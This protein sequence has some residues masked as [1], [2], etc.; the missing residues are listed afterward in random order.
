VF[1]GQRQ[2]VCALGGDSSLFGT[3]SA[4]YGRGAGFLGRAPNPRIAGS[5]TADD[6]SDIDISWVV[7]DQDFTEAVDTLGA[8]VSQVSAVLSVRTVTARHQGRYRRAG[9][10][11]FGGAVMWNVAPY[12]L[13]S[14][15]PPTEPLASKRSG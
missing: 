3:H 2:I 13:K 1:Q 8:T 10:I 11:G 15:R 9:Y 7:P 4:R 5:G 12:W 14:R 6:Y